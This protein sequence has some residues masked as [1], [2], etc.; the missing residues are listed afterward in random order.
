MLASAVCVPN[1]SARG[2]R[3]AS[4]PSEPISAWPATLDRPAANPY[5]LCSSSTVGCTWG[6]TKRSKCVRAVAAACHSGLF[7]SCNDGVTSVG[8][9]WTRA[10]YL[11]GRSLGSE[12]CGPSARACGE[13][14]GENKRE[15]GW[16][17]RGGVCVEAR[18][19]RVSSSRPL[20]TSRFG[21]RGRLDA[22]TFAAGAAS[23]PA[24]PSRVRSG[25]D[26]AP[27]PVSRAHRLG[28]PRRA[29]GETRR[30][31]AAQDP[32]GR[33]RTIVRSCHRCARPS[34]AI[35]R[36]ND[37]RMFHM[38]S[39]EKGMRGYARDMSRPHDVQGLPPA[40]ALVVVTLGRRRLAVA[41]H[42]CGR[43]TV[44]HRTQDFTA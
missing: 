20:R 21:T 23:R 25:R 38:S 2:G 5:R 43:R 41:L 16:W 11:R 12:E 7:A 31:G 29:P 14:T 17:R 26:V 42:R 40:Q 37:G 6:R 33:L 10:E 18:E 32:D 27:G 30:R 19:H 13:Q 4:S 22:L 28:R 39:K 35:L 15:K 9:D 36:K 44:W 34:A 8:S 3:L 1:V 24:A